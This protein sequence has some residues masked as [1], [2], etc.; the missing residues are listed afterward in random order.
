MEH[1]FCMRYDYNL[2]CREWSLTVKEA[3]LHF[4]ECLDS[5]PVLSWLV[6]LKNKVLLIPRLNQNV[7]FFFNSLGDTDTKKC[8]KT[9]VPDYPSKHRKLSV[10]SV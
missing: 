1:R 8:V 9:T 5:K 3:D 7:F 6:A 2:E 4:P 10:S